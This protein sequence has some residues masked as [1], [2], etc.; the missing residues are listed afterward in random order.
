MSARIRGLYLEAAR[1]PARIVFRA[2]TAHIHDVTLLLSS[3]DN[4]QMRRDLIV[5]S[6]ESCCRHRTRS[7]PRSTL[8]PD[9][10]SLLRIMK[11]TEEA[12]EV[13][14][15]VTGRYQPAQ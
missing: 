13:S 3:L 1:I 7:Q 14:Q 10:E 4:D 11:I 12:R 9:T 6:G 8:P 15:A 5:N 2:L